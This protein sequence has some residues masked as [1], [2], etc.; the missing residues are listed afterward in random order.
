MPHA[1]LHI[2]KRDLHSARKANISS[3]VKAAR[4]HLPLQPHEFFDV[5]NLVSLLI[6]SA[7]RVSWSL[8]P[9]LLSGLA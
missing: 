5:D 9:E 2:D 7:P 8:S 4:T 3:F 6:A 1:I